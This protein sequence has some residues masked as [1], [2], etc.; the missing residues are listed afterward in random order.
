M[1][2]RF[3]FRKMYVVCENGKVIAGHIAMTNLYQKKEDAQ[4]VCENRQRH[5]HRMWEDQ[6]KALPKRTVEAFY[7]VHES[8]FESDKQIQGKQP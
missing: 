5:S 8:L 7:L 6:T 1:A 4:S 2:K 3:K